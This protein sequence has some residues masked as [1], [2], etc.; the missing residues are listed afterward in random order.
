MALI[1]SHSANKDWK[2]ATLEFAGGILSGGA[3]KTPP[4]S[5]FNAITNGK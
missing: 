1:D 4:F 2:N 5:I 3:P